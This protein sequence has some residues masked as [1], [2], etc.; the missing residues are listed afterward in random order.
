MAWGQNLAPQN[1]RHLV[2]GGR[3]ALSLQCHS[4]GTAWRP[5]QDALHTAFSTVTPQFG[6]KSQ[7]SWCPKYQSDPPC[8]CEPRPSGS[9]PEHFLPYWPK[10]A[11]GSRSFR[12]VEDT[13]EPNCKNKKIPTGAGHATWGERA[14][15]PSI[16]EA[17]SLIHS[18]THACTC[19]H[20]CMYV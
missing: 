9:S 13:T 11:E 20:T 1:Q 6:F 5:L 17:P 4:K 16:C 12:A 2:S 10:Q 19:K 3:R 8:T 15:L 14:C 7:A 18:N